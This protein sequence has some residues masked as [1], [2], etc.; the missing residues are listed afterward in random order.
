VFELGSTRHAVDLSA[1]AK[2]IPISPITPVPAAP[3]AMLGAMN[4]GGR[5]VPVLDLGLLL[6]QPAANPGQGE[7]SLLLRASGYE[8]VGVV[9]RILDVRSIPAPEEANADDDAPPVVEVDGEE[10]RLLDAGAVLRGVAA[11]VAQM[12]ARAQVSVFSL[13]DKPS[14][15]PEGG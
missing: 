5:V 3:A 10:I 6:D 7:E 8:V 11:Q 12:A 13:T 14:E 4:V 1:V 2:V 15:Q 9:G